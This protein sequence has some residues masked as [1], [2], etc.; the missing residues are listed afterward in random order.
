M[1]CC[2]DLRLFFATGRGSV[3]QDMHGT[4]QMGFGLLKSFLPDR[5]REMRILR[6][7]FRGAVVVMAPRNS[8][9]KVL[10]LYEHELNSWLELTLPRVERVLDVGANDGY[11]TFGCAAAFRRLGKAGEII[12][13]E[14]EQQHVDMLRESVR[15]QPIGAT[16]ITLLQTLVGAEIGAGSTTLDAVRWRTGDPESRTHTLVKIDVEGAELNVLN[17]ALSWLNSDNYFV[18]EV[19]DESYLES[20]TRLFASRDLLLIRIDQQPLPLLGRERRA[21]TNWWLASDLGESRRMKAT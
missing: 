3:T 2:A 21:E 16:Q 7:P 13:F 5:A 10:G 1:E 17:G 19:H 8:M 18:I 11:F 20:I 14:P 9:R 15:K 12:A 6:G 4:R